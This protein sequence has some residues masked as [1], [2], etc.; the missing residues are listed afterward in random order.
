M[1]PSDKLKQH[2]AHQERD[3]QLRRILQA[4]LDELQLPAQS[5]QELEDAIALRMNRWPERVPD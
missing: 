4:A 2:L 1:T 3:E 5:G